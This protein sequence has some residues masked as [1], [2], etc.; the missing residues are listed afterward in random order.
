[1]KPHKA[2]KTIKNLLQPQKSNVVHFSPLAK[3]LFR[4]VRQMAA[5]DPNKVLYMA[6][7]V[8]QINQLE[9]LKKTPKEIQTI[10]DTKTIDDMNI[11]MVF[12]APE[13]IDKLIEM[14]FLMRQEMI[15]ANRPLIISPNGQMPNSRG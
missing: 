12:H 10:M 5:D 7:G 15:A 2:P 6:L 13:D 11:H 3:V 8:M 9:T 4:P 1:M 14:L